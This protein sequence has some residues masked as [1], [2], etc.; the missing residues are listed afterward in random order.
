MNDYYDILGVPRTATADE[1]K[2]AYR[3]LAVKY[4]PDK[5]PGDTAAEEMFK[6]INTAYDVLGDE[7]KRRQYD[8]GYYYNSNSSSNTS[9]E[10]TEKQ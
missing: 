8:S 7:E 4:H 10:N 9:S 6:K 2:K 5:N 1:I 3:K